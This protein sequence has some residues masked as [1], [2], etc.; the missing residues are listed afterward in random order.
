MRD[1]PSVPLVTAVLSNTEFPT[2]NYDISETL[3][4]LGAL[5]PASVAD[6]ADLHTDGHR[7]TKTGWRR[8]HNPNVVVSAD[9]SLL[10]L[11]SITPT[12]WTPLEPSA[13]VVDDIEWVDPVDVSRHDPQALGRPPALGALGIDAGWCSGSPDFDT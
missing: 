4:R 5:P 8:S 9:L 3:Y 7:R 13:R 10:K 1:Q 6:H 11:A 2:R 12:F